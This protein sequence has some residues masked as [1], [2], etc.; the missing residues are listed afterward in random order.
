MARDGPP[1]GGSLELDGLAMLGGVRAWLG[2]IPGLGFDEGP[3]VFELV[4]DED[5]GGGML[6]LESGFG[7][8]GFELW[9][10]L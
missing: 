5:D 9:W 2:R 3:R 4:V 1:D 6:F 10:F 7:T 8:I